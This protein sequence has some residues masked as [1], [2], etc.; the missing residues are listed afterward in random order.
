MAAMLAA[1][2][3]QPPRTTLAVSREASPNFDERRPNL[4]I[5]HHTSDD[6]LE[7]ALGTLTSPQRKV[8]AHYLIGRDGRVVQ[9]V[10]ENARAWHAGK[11]W[12]GGHTDINSASLGIELDNNGYEAFADAQIDALLAL[13]AD[14]RQRYNIPAAN[15]IGHADVAPTRKDDPSPLFPWRRLAEQGF[16]LWCGPP[17]Q[18]APPGFDLTL[19]LAAIGYD[20]AT[21][22]ASRRAFR[23]HFV[24]ED[25]PFSDE[26]ANALA[27]CLLQKKAFPGP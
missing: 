6:T 8:S 10:E 17:L 12:W 16:G 3:P 23:R 15:F 22:E 5:I 26:Y 11:S 14:I 4:V 13:L 25:Q 1:C 20:P 7:E 2:A 27:V 21:P 24:P 18:P 19:A 9:L